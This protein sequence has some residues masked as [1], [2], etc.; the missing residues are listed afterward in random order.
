MSALR[1]KINPLFFFNPKSLR[2]KLWA[3]LPPA[4]KRLQIWAE[5]SVTVDVYSSRSSDS[6]PLPSLPSASPGSW[7]RDA[8]LQQLSVDKQQLCPFALRG[9]LHFHLHV[10][11][12]ADWM[13]EWLTIA[14]RGT[15]GITPELVLIDISAA[16]FDITA[17]ST[18]CWFSR[19]LNN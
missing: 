15:S 7:H 9:S 6:D 8:Q 5:P 2:N 18:F 17:P 4:G 14:S 12:R 11:L 3:L 16:M 1:E 13:L 19:R 10:E